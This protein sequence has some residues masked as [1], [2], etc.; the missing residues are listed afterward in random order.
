MSGKQGAGDRAERV[1]ENMRSYRE[2]MRARGLR[3][4][5]L[6]VPDTR[7]PEF[8]A[9]VRRQSLVAAQHPE[10]QAVLEWIE[11]VVDTDGWE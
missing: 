11:D 6:W 2:R 4:V 8:Q 1:R 5:T 10:E 7:S 9:E 3:P